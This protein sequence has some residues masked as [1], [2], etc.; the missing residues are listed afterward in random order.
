MVSEGRRKE[1][2]ILLQNQILKAVARGVKQEQWSRDLVW[3]SRKIDEIDVRQALSNARQT[4]R[5]HGWPSVSGLI[6]SKDKRS[7]WIVHVNLIPD[8]STPP[9]S[10]PPPPPPSQKTAEETNDDRDDYW[11]GCVVFFCILFPIW[12]GSILSRPPHSK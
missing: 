3:S 7:K 5:E 11:L 6:Y 10:P 1:R 8:L 2:V 9:P 4:M 12:L